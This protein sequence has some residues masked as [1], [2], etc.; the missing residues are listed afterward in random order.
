MIEKKKLSYATFPRRPWTYKKD[1]MS[2]LTVIMFEKRKET[3]LEDVTCSNFF[4]LCRL[5]K[6]KESVA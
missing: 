3:F 6:K 4:S 2:S 5:Q 1:V